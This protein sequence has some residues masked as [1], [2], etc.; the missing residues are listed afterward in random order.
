MMNMIHKTLIGRFNL[1]TDGFARTIPQY[2]IRILSLYGANPIWNIEYFLGEVW[3]SPDSGEIHTIYVPDN[4][5]R[6]GVGTHL[7]HL[8]GVELHKLG[9]KEMFALS[10]RSK[11]WQA[12]GFHFIDYKPC[13]SYCLPWH[14]LPGLGKYIKQL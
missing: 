9:H 2:N 3:I 13:P 5:R 6:Q 12:L 4:V 10:P 1:R 7:V 11:F 14:D 8:S